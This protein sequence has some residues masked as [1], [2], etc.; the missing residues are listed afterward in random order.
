MPSTVRNSNKDAQILCSRLITE[1]AQP[2]ED[3]FTY[4]ESK[5]NTNQETLL[6]SKLLTRQS[7]EN[8]NKIVVIDQMQTQK[9]YRDVLCSTLTKKNSDR[10]TIRG[11]PDNFNLAAI[12]EEIL[13]YMMPKQD[14]INST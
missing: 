6:N 12:R 4:S 3:I 1:S 7:E 10:H 2:S 9:R 14:I 11:S 8:G 5:N 13:N